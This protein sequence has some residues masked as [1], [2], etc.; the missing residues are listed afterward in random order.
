MRRWFVT[1]W[2]LW[3]LPRHALAYVLA[4]D[5]AAL[6]VLTARLRDY[7]P[8]LPDLR[9]AAWL[10][11]CAGLGVE[12]SHWVERLR[13]RHRD[14]P[15]KDLNT[16][17]TVAAALVLRPGAAALFVV[18]LYLWTWVRVMRRGRTHRWTFSAA[19][20]VLGVAT[21]GAVYRQG[22]GPTAWQHGLVPDP[23]APLVGLGAGMLSVAVNIALVGGVV[24]LTDPAVG[25]R[26]AFGG[27]WRE[28]GLEASAICL[29][30]LVAAGFTVSPW[31]IL[32]ALPVLLLLQRTLLVAQLQAAART[33]LKTGLPNATWWHEVA[34]REFERARR[35]DEQIAVLIADLDRFKRINDVYGH[36]AGDVVL[37]R[38]ADVLSA[39]VREYDVVG[40]FGGEEFVVVLPSTGPDQAGQIAERLRDRVAALDL[41]VADTAGRPRRVHGLTVSIGLACYPLHGRD[42]E[43]LLRMA[44]AA[45]YTAKAAGRNRV[46]SAPAGGTP[47]DLPGRPTVG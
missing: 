44:D 18:G 21:A 9:W 20:V 14:A 15:Y 12:A 5:L 33:D 28:Q 1:G 46:R 11:L 43:D 40:R 3:S 45:L 17:W 36:L 10:L 13:E 16:V 22:V 34:Q 24:L 31:L 4:V 23:L 25:L 19:T 32:L 35:F 26:R 6:A 7:P 42:L 29:G 41:E 27:R 38:V 47:E 37:R 30:I 39:E 2:P 8:T